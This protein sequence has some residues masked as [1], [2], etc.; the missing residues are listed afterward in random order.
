MPTYLAPGVYIE[1]IDS[2]PPP[3]QGVGTNI[4]AF[5]GAAR[6]GP[7]E[8]PP[9][10]VT[11]YADF[12]RTFGGAFEI[13]GF[14]YSQDLPPAVKGYF[15]NGGQ[16]AYIAR[17]TPN[18]ATLAAAATANI[19]LPGGITTRLTSDVPAG[20]SV[21]YL[22]D[23]RGITEGT[24]LAL[25]T[26]AATTVKVA[27]VDPASG[28]VTL[29]AALANAAVLSARSTIV[30]TTL[31]DPA[32]QI[33]A[34]GLPNPIAAGPESNTAGPQSLQLTAANPG[35]WGSSIQIVP[36][37]QSAARSTAVAVLS[38]TQ[39]QLISGAGFYVGAWIEIDNGTQKKYVTVTAVAGPVLTVSGAA[40]MAADVTPGKTYVSSCEF[41]LTISYQDPVEMS[42]VQENYNGLTL[43]NVPGRYY[44]EQLANSALVTVVAGPGGA[45][46]GN[47]FLF[48]SAPDGLTA[49]SLWENGQD[50]AP[51]DPDVLGYD[52]GPGK[53][54]GLLSISDLNGVT[55][56]AA[57]GTTSQ[58][59]QQALIDQCELL[60]DR[61]AV[62]DPVSEGD[63]PATLN[64]IENQRNLY[65][66]EYAA[67]YYP[68][69]VI[70]DPISGP[71]NTRTIAPSGH[72]LGV[73]ARVD[74]TRGVYKAPA[75]ELVLG[76]SGFE[77]AVSTGLQDI[78][79][80][81][82]INALRDFT[83]IQRGLRIYGARC[84]TSDS[85]WNYVNVRRLFIFIEQS[86]NIGTQ[87]VVFEPNDQKLWAQV[88]Q[89][90]SIFLT[91][92]WQSGA[93]MGSTVA[94]AFYVKADQTTMTED[95]ILN[96][97]FVMEIG[98]APVRPA[99]FVIFRISQW[100]GGT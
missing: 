56:L 92:V 3:I 83:S 24:E 90:V 13:Q 11:S 30:A 80:P 70:P 87:W 25:S 39:L 47:P 71:P 63:Q 27:S 79:N 96:G 50:P 68:R 84:V 51:A 21:I 43:A 89:S 55:L 98:I 14:G 6:R 78:L 86:L 88:T 73:Y 46:A 8:G 67:L 26:L 54:S 60:R 16:V 34:T 59:V 93:L 45:P 72:I 97:R 35:T 49:V 58:T 42:T 66:S 57:P 28:A 53:R 74:E 2:G 85:E 40:L 61:F 20:A 15:D 100:D 10:L 65:D 4:P 69:L 37:I 52:N 81:L 77:T 99:E 7:I 82:N 62:L 33:E 31:A 18:P 38:G 12:V 75:N 91:G 5:V 19:T 44:S 23:L 29:T 22:R 1:E 32:T 17:A 36:S 95:D 48:P 9:T 41:G 94:E 64:D 76:V